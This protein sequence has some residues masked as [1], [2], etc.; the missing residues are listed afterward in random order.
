MK[1]LTLLHWDDDNHTPIT[2]LNGYYLGS[3]DNLPAML[4]AIASVKEL[5]EEPFNI[6]ETTI[7][8]DCLPEDDKISDAIADFLWNVDDITPEQWDL[9][10]QA[11][12]EV[13]KWLIFYEKYCK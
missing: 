9:M 5:L 6:R 13:E 11:E 3:Y 8:W 2:W 1:T 12:Q 4:R 10:L 7:C